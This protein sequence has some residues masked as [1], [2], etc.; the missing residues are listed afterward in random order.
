MLEIVLAI[1]NID[2]DRLLSFGRLLLSP[3]IASPILERD[4]DLHHLF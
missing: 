2:G 1:D 3:A 4:R